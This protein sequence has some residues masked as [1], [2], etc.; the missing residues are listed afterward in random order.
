MDH[1]VK[2]VE[3]PFSSPQHPMGS[4]TRVGRRA[5]QSNSGLAHPMLFGELE[6]GIN[7]AAGESI[8][9]FRF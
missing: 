1:S 7:L 4:R 6:N 8:G 3:P 9:E 5:N 2:G